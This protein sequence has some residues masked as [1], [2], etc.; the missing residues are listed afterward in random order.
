MLVRSGHV[1]GENEWAGEVKWDGIRLQARVEPT[2][3]RVRS[4]PGRDCTTLFPELGALSALAG[5]RRRL[6]L[7]GE[8]VCL[9]VDGAPDFSSVRARLFGTRRGA[10]RQPV[11][12]VVFDV[13]HD[14]GRA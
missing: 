14:T 11:T 10:A 4:R 7:D 2:R 12:F 8:L 5:R 6:L 1:P 9:A 3:V 13:L